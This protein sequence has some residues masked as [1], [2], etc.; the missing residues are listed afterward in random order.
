MLFKI[1]R[2]PAD[3]LDINTVIERYNRENPIYVL[4]SFCYLYIL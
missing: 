1:P 2:G 4:I 3:L